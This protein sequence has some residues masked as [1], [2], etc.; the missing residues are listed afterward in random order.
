MLFHV[1]ST[2]QE[3]SFM[4]NSEKSKIFLRTQEFDHTYLTSWSGIMCS[5]RL[6]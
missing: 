5:P 4:Y 6:S 3:E 2:I 1:L